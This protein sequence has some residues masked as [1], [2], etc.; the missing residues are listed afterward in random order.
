MKYTQGKYILSKKQTLAKQIYDFTVLC[1]DIAAQAQIGQFVHILPEGKGGFT[2][3]RPISICDIDKEAGTI[4]LVFQVKGDGTDV[5]SQIPTGGPV[6][7][8]GPLGH[9]FTLT[10]KNDHVIIAGGGIGVPPLLGLAKYYGKNAVVILGFRNAEA[11]ILQ[12]D[13][14]KTGA[15]VIMCTDDGSYGVCGNAAGP[16]KDYIAESDAVMSCGPMRMLEAISVISAEHDV[17]CQ[18]SLEERMG[19]GV[20]ACLVCAC[21]LNVNGVERMGHVCKDGPVFDSKEVVW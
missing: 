17:K 14:E 7:I 8:V 13:F 15:K 20:G 10:D 21:K 19:C 18:V 6:D 3:R 5:I 16:L 12:K 11:V 4:R 1:P 9:G 2:L